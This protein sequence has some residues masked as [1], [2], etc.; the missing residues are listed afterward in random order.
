M[1]LQII[2][3]NQNLLFLSSDPKLVITMVLKIGIRRGIGKL[4]VNSELDESA[5]IGR[6]GSETQIFFQQCLFFIKKIKQIVKKNIL[7]KKSC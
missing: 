2:W 1:S 4:S 3:Q 6:I 5:E 7:S